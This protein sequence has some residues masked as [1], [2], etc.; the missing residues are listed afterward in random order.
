MV[1]TNG[2]FRKTM[3]ARK[4]SG[5]D[6]SASIPQ[7]IPQKSSPDCNHRKWATNK[8]KKPFPSL[9]TFD[10]KAILLKLFLWTA[11]T[12]VSLVTSFAF[13]SSDG[14]SRKSLKSGS[15]RSAG[16]AATRRR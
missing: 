11:H 8:K 16:C 13:G 5:N 12:A 7:A 2:K 15:A 9:D 6:E 3:K 1:S 14:C 10:S 4:E